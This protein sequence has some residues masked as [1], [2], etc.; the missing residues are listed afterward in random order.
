MAQ[1]IDLP[2]NKFRA[3]DWLDLLRKIQGVLERLGAGHVTITVRIEHTE[4]A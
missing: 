3:S 2:L 1:V 4:A